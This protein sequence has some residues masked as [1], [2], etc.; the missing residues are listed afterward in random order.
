MGCTEYVMTNE[1]FFKGPREEKLK[2]LEGLIKRK[3]EGRQRWRRIHLDSR[4][5]SLTV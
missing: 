1:I 2:S 5:L 4:H 3:V